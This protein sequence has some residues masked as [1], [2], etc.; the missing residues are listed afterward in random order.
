MQVGGVQVP[1]SKAFKYGTA[2]TFVAVL[3]IG[4]A[5]GVIPGVAQLFGWV[6]GIFAAVVGGAAGGYYAASSG[7]LGDSQTGDAAKIGGLVAALGNLLAAP[8][9]FVIAAASSVIF[10][11][12][13]GTGNQG[14]VSNIVN[15]LIGGV[16]G[17]GI[18]LI[19]GPIIAL[20]GGIIGAMIA[21]KT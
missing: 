21:I 15:N 16:L 5:G 13:M 9:T 8:L 11:E 10:T 1:G 6:F 14:L 20:I 2:I 3:V 4:G 7:G 18:G 19:T 12:A 17:F